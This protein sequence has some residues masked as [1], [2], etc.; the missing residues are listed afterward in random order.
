IGWIIGRI[1]GRVTKEILTRAEVDQ[2]LKREGHLNFEIT[3]LSDVVVRW[4][5]YLAFI[6]AAA[7]ILGI[8]GLTNFVNS[9]LFSVLPGIV[10]AGIVMLVAY[11]IGLYFKEGLTEHE[12][13]EESIYADL[14]GKAVFWLSMFFGVALALDIFFRLAL[15]A[16]TVSLVPNLLMII[17]AGVSLGIAIAIGLGLKDIVSE[18]A[19]DYAEEFK[20]KR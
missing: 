15:Q 14:S 3:S 8:S 12:E 17:V 20:D 6:S 16:S 13:D 4:F 18:M 10:G 9:L 19:E 11:V 1:F 2:H 7:K 5:I